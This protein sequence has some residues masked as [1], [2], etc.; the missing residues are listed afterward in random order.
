MSDPRPDMSSYVQALHD[1]GAQQALGSGSGP[2]TAVAQPPHPA[3]LTKLF[4]TVRA[5]AG[6]AGGTLA[7]EGCCFVA[8]RL[9]QERRFE[10]LSAVEGFLRQI[11][12]SK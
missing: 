12:A 9:G 6:L 4:A 7:P 5:K 10:D 1:A 8:G 3:R 2:A 11:G